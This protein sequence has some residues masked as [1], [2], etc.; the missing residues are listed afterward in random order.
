[1]STLPRSEVLVLVVF[2]DLLQRPLFLNVHSITCFFLRSIPIIHH[3]DAWMSTVNLNGTCLCYTVRVDGPEVAS[4]EF[5][6]CRGHTV[7]GMSLLRRYVG[8]DRAIR[9]V[10]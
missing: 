4:L 6:G 7:V 2:H 10:L 8:R 1:M 9:R 5:V 3:S